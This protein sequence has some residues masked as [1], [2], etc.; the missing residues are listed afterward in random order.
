MEP[1]N[2]YHPWKRR[3]IY[4]HVSFRGVVFTPKMLIFQLQDTAPE[5]H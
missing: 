5:G 2:K 1:K 4:I 3:N